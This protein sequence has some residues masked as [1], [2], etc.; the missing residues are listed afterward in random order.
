MALFVVMAFLFMLTAAL[1]AGFAVNVSERRVDDDGLQAQNVM[2]MAEG[3]LQQAMVNRAGIG[4]LNSPP[5]A[6]ESA[7]VNVAGGTVDVIV[8]QLRPVV[9]TAAAIYLIRSHAIRTQ[10][11]SG[12]EASAQ[13]TVTELA[14]WQSGTMQVQ[15]GWTSLSGITKNG[16]SGTISGV[17]QCGAKGSLPAVSVP[18]NPGYVGSQSP[19]AGS[20]PLIDTTGATAAAS[21]SASPIQWANIVN[22]SALTPTYTIPPQSFPTTTQFADTNFWPIIKIVN[23]PTNLPPNAPTGGTD[24]TLPYAGRGMLIVEGNMVISGSNMWSGIT[25][26]GGTITSN[27]NNSVDGAVSSGLNVEL[28][29]NVGMESVGNGTKHFQYN[30]CSVALATAAMGHLQGFS[31]TWSTSW[32][33]Y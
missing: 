30:S 18:A 22:G 24:F 15:A 3:G 4:L 27:G 16:A 14:S 25:L 12:S 1:A 8:T 21:A 17:D 26:V 10:A 33:T 31:N 19:L 9:G 7:R 23:P 29:Y 2:A 11:T 13:Q 6:A 20:T 5:A 28:G 32:P